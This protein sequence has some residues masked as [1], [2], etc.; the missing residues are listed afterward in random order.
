M[1]IVGKPKVSATGTVTRFGQWQPIETAP[2]DE[3]AI[4]VY[5]DAEGTRLYAV[6][7]WDPVLRSWTCDWDGQHYDG[8]GDVF[9]GWMP[10]PPP[11]GVDS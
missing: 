1:S 10:L 6:V 2:R 7:F 4:L 8:P 11:P 5:G 3:S 9:H